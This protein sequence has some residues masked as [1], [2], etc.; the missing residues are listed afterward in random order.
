M[1]AS[2]P[3]VALKPGFAD[4][5]T[6]AGILLGGGV[7]VSGFTPPELQAATVRAARDE[8]IVG[9][10]EPAKYCHFVLSGCVRTVRLMRDGRR[11]V[12]EFLF[13][14]DLFGWEALGEHHFGAE[15]VTCVTHLRYPQ[16]RLE[17]LAER[18]RIF[19]AQL[20]ALTA[21]QL[22]ANR[23]RM[24]L[25]GRKRAAER[26][27]TFILEMAARPGAEAETSIDLP[28]SRTDIADYL[29]LTIETVCRGIARFRREGLIAAERTRIVIRDRRAL[30]LVG[31]ESLH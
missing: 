10:G 5:G 2:T 21:G 20:R 26:I 13:A 22:R 15:A 27:A 6:V 16:R 4:P 28:M 24:V 18:D 25:L 7:S 3:A 14:G 9:Q 19:A 31:R 17:A 12:G 8:E 1:L 11:Q 23:D 30:E 29:G